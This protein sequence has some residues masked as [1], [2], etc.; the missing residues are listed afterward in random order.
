[1]LSKRP[2]V[3]L[4]N[5]KCGTVLWRKPT[6]CNRENPFL[7][8]EFAEFFVSE[9]RVQSVQEDVNA[10]LQYTKTFSLFDV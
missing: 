9:S 3:V 8:L 2:L 10:E 5:A 1:L 6:P 4:I 7:C